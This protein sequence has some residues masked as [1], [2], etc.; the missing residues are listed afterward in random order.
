MSF[1]GDDIFFR[2]VVRHCV[3]ITVVRRDRS[4]KT[5][6]GGS[7][8]LDDSGWRGLGLGSSGGSRRT[9]GIVW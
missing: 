9:G 2:P 1:V 3:M 5:S 6:G 7:F 8:G 4:A